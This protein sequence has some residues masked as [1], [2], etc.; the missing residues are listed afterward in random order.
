MDQEGIDFYFFQNDGMQFLPIST[1]I[2]CV[3]EISLEYSK[4]I[5]MGEDELLLSFN[6]NGN[7][8]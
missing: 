4:A 7:N 3:I 1:Q 8:I 5:V 6:L 2:G